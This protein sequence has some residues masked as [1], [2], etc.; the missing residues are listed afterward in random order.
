MKRAISYV[1]AIFSLN[2]RLFINALEGLSDEQMKERVSEHNNPINWIATHTVWARFNTCLFLGKSVQNPYSGM[3][4][5][6]KAYDPSIP[7]PSLTEIKD[8]WR[9]ATELLKQA[10]AEVTDEQLAADS[11]LKN[12]TGDFSNGGTIA[13]LAQHESYD[14]GQIAFL[15]K[16]HTQQAMAY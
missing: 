1:E 10:F 5:N 3:F 14:I 11:P 12:P 13:F 8:E 7:L 6:F 9:K 2:D 15:K 4:E 16:L